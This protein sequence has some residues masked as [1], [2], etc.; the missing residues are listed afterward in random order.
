MDKFEE[1]EKK[2]SF[3]EFLIG[4]GSKEYSVG[5]IKHVISAAQILVQQITSLNEYDAKSPQIAK[6]SLKK[7]KEDEIK[8]F[9]KFYQKLLTKE[10]KSHI[11]PQEVE[12]DIQKLKKFTEIA[13]RMKGNNEKRHNFFREV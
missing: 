11:T 8:D 1:I 13:K 6:S 5:A 3:A 2:I 4:R 7:F 10:E 9:S 12:E